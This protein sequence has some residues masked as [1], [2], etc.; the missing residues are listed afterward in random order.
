M[1]ALEGD[2]NPIFAWVIFAVS[3]IITPRCHMF[4]T[5]AVAVES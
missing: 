4:D 5:G 2:Q 3:V 1:A